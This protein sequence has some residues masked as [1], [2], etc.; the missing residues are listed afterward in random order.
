MAIVPVSAELK[1]QGYKFYILD[2]ARGHDG[3]YK[4]IEDANKVVSGNLNF[5]A[6]IKP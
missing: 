1:A 2:S 3:P 4:S 5:I 6:I